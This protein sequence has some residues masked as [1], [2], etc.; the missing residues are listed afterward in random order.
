MAEGI[1]L[2]IHQQGQK[3]DKKEKDL[4]LLVSGFV[5]G[6][7][8]YIIEFPFSSSDFVKNLE[9]KIQRWQRK[10]KGSR[11]TKGQFLEVPTLIIKTLSKAQI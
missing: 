2:I 5:D 4:N 1:L 7:L 3:R 10:L 6:K 11:S 8:I 9:I